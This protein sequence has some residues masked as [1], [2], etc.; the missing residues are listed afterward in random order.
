MCYSCV[1][2]FIAAREMFKRAFDKDSIGKEILLTAKICHRVNK[3]IPSGLEKTKSTVLRCSVG[4]DRMYIL[5][6]G[7]ELA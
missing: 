6:I 1:I 2:S 3:I 4:L 7:L 5:G